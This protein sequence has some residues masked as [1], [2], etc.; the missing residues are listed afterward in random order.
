MEVGIVHAHYETLLGDF[1]DI[2]KN[3][4]NQINKCIC[5]DEY[6]N[7]IAIIYMNENNRTTHPTLRFKIFE[8]N[9]RLK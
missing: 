1:H 7:S 9:F 8:L 3:A 6:R 2:I 4:I 5:I